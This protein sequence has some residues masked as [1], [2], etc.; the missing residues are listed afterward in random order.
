MVLTYYIIP[1]FLSILLI[2]G[3][4]KNAYESFINGAKM[5]QALKNLTIHLGTEDKNKV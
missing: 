1:V 4:R 2:V 5:Q 3:I